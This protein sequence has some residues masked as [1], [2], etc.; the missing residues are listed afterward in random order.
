MKTIALFFLCVPAWAGFLDCRWL[1]AGFEESSELAQ[2]VERATWYPLIPY[3]F[4]GGAVMIRAHSGAGN[5]GI[6]EEIE[7]TAKNTAFRHRPDTI[8]NFLIYLRQPFFDET[9][10]SEALL[11]EQFTESQERHRRT[12]RG[13]VKGI[14]VGPH[15]ENVP[16]YVRLQKNAY[17]S[18][19]TLGE[20]A[21]QRK[22]VPKSHRI[23]TGPEDL[24]WQEA[25]AKE[26]R[27]IFEMERIF[28][29]K[30]DF[31]APYRMAALDQMLRITLKDPNAFIDDF[32]ETVALVPF[33]ELVVLRRGTRDLAAEFSAAL[34]NF[35]NDIET[36]GK[37]AQ[38]AAYIT[39]Q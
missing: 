33:A 30:E 28:A 31:H 3:R 36:R 17:Y 7:Q 26:R 32:L 14:I 20:Y 34:Q 5:H 22:L 38:L 6:S 35:D 27:D 8:Q 23:G 19:L 2:R 1:L 24:K 16:Y 18:L 15:P 39:W 21:V 13:W 29:L 10:K 37:V 25:S 4:H 12:W 11:R 9:A